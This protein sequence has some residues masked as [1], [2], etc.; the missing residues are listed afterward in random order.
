MKKKSI[1]AEKFLVSRAGVDSA[2]RARLLANPRETI[3]KELGA[4]LPEDHEIHVHE[5]S[6][7]TTHLVLPPRDKRTEAEREA[8][9]TG[10]ASL[11]YLRKTLHDP[12]PPLRPP[13]P[14]GAEARRKKA[15]TAEALVKAGRESI[16]RGLA[17]LESTLD[18]NGAWHCIRFNVADPDIPRHYERPAFI[19][20]LCVLALERCG[21]ARAE[22]MCA[23]SR[24][25]LADTM[26][27]PG[28][29]RYYRHLPQDLD[30]TALC[31]LVIG[32]HPWILLGRNVP[33]ILANRD[34]E[35]R[36]MT[37]VLT[38]DEPSVVSTFRIEADPVV[39]A[40]VIAY[41]GDHPETRRAQRW[42]EDLIAEGN[43]E[44]SSKW[45]PDTSAIYYAISRAMSRAQPALHRLRPVLADRILDL[46]DERG[47]FGNILQT[48]QAVSALYNV[49]G[50]ERIDA[51]HQI[52]E[53]INSQHE[54]GSWPELL[55]F[56]DQSLKWG[57]VGQIGH[58]SEAVTSAFCIEALEHLVE[59][60]RS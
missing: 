29:W 38:E 45:Y 37:W 52:E 17:F 35:G 26:E 24:A 36:F 18:E 12:A 42:L 53:F 22:A 46:C 56:G 3:E 4:A 10:A 19:T 55:A 6:P 57:T 31:S 54:D 20:A 7:A 48:A 23:A 11:E 30:S 50:L 9:R 13:A 1:D 33:H 21:E 27:Y 44:E 43:V 49:G 47:E 16:R 32:S 14:K 60:L 25:Y 28:L 58:G 40:N 41:L 2:F 8:A 51:K 15:T 5:E 59:L 34:E 39:N